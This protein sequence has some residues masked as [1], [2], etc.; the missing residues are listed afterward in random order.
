VARVG[1]AGPS[2][3]WAR[4]GDYFFPHSFYLFCFSILSFRKDRE[5]WGLSKGFET[6]KNVGNLDYEI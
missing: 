6:L 5:H 4:V 1:S 3:S 2:D